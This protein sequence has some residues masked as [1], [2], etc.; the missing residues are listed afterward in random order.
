VGGR[1]TLPQPTLGQGLGLEP[2]YPWD[3]PRPIPSETM[4]SIK[5]LHLTGAAILVSR[6]I[7]FLQRP[8]QAS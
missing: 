7:K 2:V 5:A 3:R 6:D 1:Y 8:R 4:I